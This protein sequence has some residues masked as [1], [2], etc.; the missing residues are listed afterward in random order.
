MRWIAGL[1]LL[2]FGACTGQPYRSPKGYDLTK[3]IKY[4][5]PDVLH[6]ISG[7]FL[8]DDVLYAEQDE[9][10]R[11]YY[12]CLGDRQTRS[13][14]FGKKGDFEDIALLGGTVV[15]LRSDGVLFTFP[16]SG[17]GSGEAISKEW[18]GLLPTGEY[19][20]LYGD[21]VTRQVYVLCKHC[22]GKGGGYIFRLGDDGTPQPAGEFSIDTKRLKGDRGFH[23]SALVKNDWTNEWYILSSV[24]KLLVVTDAHWQ[25]KSVYPLNPA[26]FNQPEGIAFDRHR[27]L[28]ISN[29]GGRG[30]NGNVLKFTYQP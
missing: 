23:P 6:E 2:V 13:V 8:K 20:G 10:G 18:S 26:V 27:N 21:S 9:E 17:I 12:L 25:V 19:E 3:P 22:Q 14:K 1:C 7:I 28:Y 15:M 5:M 16:F 11:V 30:G 29:E 4:V 24:N